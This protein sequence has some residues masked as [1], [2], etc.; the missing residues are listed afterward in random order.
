MAEKLAAT[1]CATTA[2]QSW[3][4]YCSQNHASRCTTITPQHAMHWRELAWQARH[5][6]PQGILLDNCMSSHHC[7]LAQQEACSM[8]STTSEPQL[9]ESDP[10][11]DRSSNKTS[12]WFGTSGEKIIIFRFALCPSLCGTR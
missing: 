5:M 9:Q 3:L 2:C 10:E 11:V 6:Q 4:W 1:P 12:V 7:T 8:P